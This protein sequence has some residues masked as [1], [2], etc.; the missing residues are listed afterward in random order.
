MLLRDILL[1]ASVKAPGKIHRAV[2]DDFGFLVADKV[3]VA[4]VL[5]DKT[6]KYSCKINVIFYSDIY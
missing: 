3:A 6:I 5:G 2:I 1:P 4:T